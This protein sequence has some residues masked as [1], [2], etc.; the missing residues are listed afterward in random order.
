MEASRHVV[1]VDPQAIVRPRQARTEFD[2]AALQDLMQSIRTVGIL[3][4]VHLLREG[5]ELRVEDGERRI[6]AAIALAMPTVP[7][8]ISDRSLSEEDVLQR[9]LI[10]NCIREGLLPIEQARAIRQLMDKWGCTAAEAG[11]RIGR[12][13]S[14]VSK[15]LS[16]LDANQD[17]QAKLAAGGIGLKAAYDLSR[18][19]APVAD[20]AQRA[21]RLTKLTAPLDGSRSI[22]FHGIDSTMR[23]CI[24]A[25]EEL[26]AR[27]KAADKQGIELPTCLA[28]FKD[29]AKA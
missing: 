9:Q 14:T 4:P 5:T 21:V 11:G 7:A 6:R 27:L 18:G 2:E 24:A 19:Q 28:M 1:D 3:H 25:A 13:A 15:L 12:S 29:Q 17:V 10:A 22:T 23:A 20:G 8:L 16:L 26:L